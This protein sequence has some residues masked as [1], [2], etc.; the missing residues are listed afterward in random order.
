MRILRF[1]RIQWVAL[2][3]GLDDIV[4]SHERLRWLRP[5][6]NRLLFWRDLS[7]PRAV[8]LRL[9]LEALGPIFVKFGQM[10][11]TR[12]DLLPTDIADEL[13][14][15]QDRVPP[16]PA[17][18]VIATLTRC[19]RKPVEQVFASFDRE[20]TASAS[21]AQ[22]HFAQLP[23]GT[24]VA[25]KVLRPGIDAV[26][27]HD[28]ALLDTAASLVE[29]V[30]ADARRLRPREV[31]KEF[32]KTIRDELDLTREAANCSQL[33]RNFRHSPLLLVP[34]IYWDYTNE[35]V[36]VMERMSGIPIARVDELTRAGIDLKRL[37]RA[38]VEI[39]FTQVFRDGY[40]HADMHPGNIFV[41]VDPGN[42]GKYIALDFGIMG[43]LSETDKSY[44]AQNFLAFFRR[45]YH[46]VATAHLESG[47]VPA[48]T[49]VDEL[50]AEIRVVLEPIFDRPLK[51]ISLGKVLVSLFRASRRFNV[52]IQPQLTLLQKT[53]LAVEGLGRQ[54]DPDLDLWV[55][56]KPFLERW[57]RDQIGLPALQRRLL[58]EAPYIVAALP[59]IPRLLH[60]RLLAPAAASDTAL[61]ALAAAQRT[62]NRWLALVAVLLVIVA[63]L[64][65][66][67]AL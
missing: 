48:D 19:Y 64:L 1:L 5:W 39:F 35:E 27:A 42:H 30:S 38:G 17:E 53:L 43:T 65:L 62:R 13:A 66:R 31:V 59:E 54:L 16:F 3:F 49:R 25:V 23:D 10:L 6:V 24:P 32:E 22:V 57:M 67:R 34:E 55:T 28:L 40:F 51:E 63:V 45:D 12:R 20:P 21:V 4:L 58:A 56:A 15:L 9:A 36:L 18:E 61:M 29:R 60:Q 14:K 8:R 50:E 52:Q 37:A 11:S 41:A 26:I 2:R 47:W 7:T 33:R 44:L 46:R